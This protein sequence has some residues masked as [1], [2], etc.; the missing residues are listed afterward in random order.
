MKKI[1]KIPLIIIGVIFVLFVGLVILG[2]LSDDESDSQ[3]SQTM[4]YKEID[5]ED[6]VSFYNLKLVAYSPVHNS[7]QQQLI[8]KSVQ[9]VIYSGGEVKGYKIAMPKKTIEPNKYGIFFYSI[10]IFEKVDSQEQLTANLCLKFNPDKSDVIEITSVVIGD[11]TL[12]FD[13]ALE[14]AINIFPHSFFEEALAFRVEARKQN[15]LKIKVKKDEEYAT[16]LTPEGWLK[17]SVYT[18][19]LLLREGILDF[20][21]YRVGDV[22]YSGNRQEGITVNQPRAS[23]GFQIIAI[24]S[25]VDG[26]TSKINVYLRYNKKSQMSLIEKIEIKGGNGKTQVANSFE[27]K[28]VVL[29]FLLPTLMNQGN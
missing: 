29:M 10:D 12:Y 3:S 28:Y 4:E 26:V 6:L 13:D 18:S 7:P 1:I 27:E 5:G 9:D 24:T 16:T 11:K 17:D 14:Y 23:G 2:L 8:G 25:V 15:D 22:F 19:L 20:N 21:D